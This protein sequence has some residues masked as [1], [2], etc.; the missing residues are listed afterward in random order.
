MNFEI[1][2][3]EDI[4]FIYKDNLISH[5]TG[6]EAS[7]YIDP[8][9]AIVSSRSALECLV[10]GLIRQHNIITQADNLCDKIELC[11]DKH[12]FIL[13]AED[14]GNKATYVRQHG[15]KVVHAVTTNNMH[16]A[17]KQNIATAIEVVSSLYDVIKIAFDI[18][19]P[20]DKTKIPFGDYEIIRA[21]KKIDGEIIC[22]D[23]NYFVRENDGDVYYLQ[24]LPL[25]AEED[26][27]TLFTRRNEEARNNI[28]NDRRRH[29][30]LPEIKTIPLPVGSDRKYVL[31]K[32]FDDSYLL[33]ERFKNFSLKDAISI[34]CD[35]L[36]ILLE[37]DKVGNGMHHRHITPG[38]VII[39][40]DNGSVLASL[41]NMQTAKIVNNP[42]TIIGGLRGIIESSLYIPNDVR[43]FGEENLFNVNWEQVD[44]YST[45]MIMLYCIDPNLV[46]DTVNIDDLFK[47]G[48]SDNMVDLFELIFSGSTAYIPSLEKVLE[49]LENEHC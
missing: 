16:I 49:V 11:L 21:V 29:T 25:T 44:V 47:Y 1:L 7:V 45:A 8:Y 19:V 37:L 26:D 39:T 28:R 18:A 4:E 10:N 6:A 32:V 40:P 3:R 36:H 24:C 46:R 38:C 15:N 17:N 27:T 43:G 31:Y 33:S 12:V 14:A 30:Y 9:N 41:V 2:K 35:L 20:F 5:T 48:F 34:G 13:G 42:G 23:Y 22:G